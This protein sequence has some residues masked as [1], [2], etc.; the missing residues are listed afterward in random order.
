MYFKFDKEILMR[1]YLKPE[2][3]LSINSAFY[4]NILVF[5][6]LQL[7]HLDYGHFI[8]IPMAGTFC[9]PAAPSVKEVKLDSHPNKHRV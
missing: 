8:H 9:R 6:Y 5:L 4:I 3:T 7:H 1:M 2:L